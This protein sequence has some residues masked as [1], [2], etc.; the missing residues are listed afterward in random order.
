MASKAQKI[1]GA[2]HPITVTPN[3]QRVVV[4]I[5]RQVV[6]DTRNALTLQEAS[7]G[8]VQYVP[9]SDVDMSRLERSRTPSALSRATARITAPSGAGQMSRGP[10][11]SLTKQSRQSRI[12]WRFIPIV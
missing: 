1:P 7:Y 5:A 2:D 9:R 4:K 12:I 6:A 3:P 10:T 8:P 11:R